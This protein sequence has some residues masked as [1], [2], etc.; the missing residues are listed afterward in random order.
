VSGLYFD[1]SGTLWIAGANDGIMN[2]T[3]SD[4]DT[5]TT[6]TSIS[7]GIEEAVAE[8][9]GDSTGGILLMLKHETLF[10]ITRPIVHAQHFR[11]YLE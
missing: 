11:E 9:S 5:S 4:A 10:T 8:P 6:W 3:P 2:Y 1:A 7:E